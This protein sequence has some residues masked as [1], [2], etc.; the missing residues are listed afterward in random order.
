MSSLQKSD[1]FVAREVGE[2]M[3]LVPV[4]KARADLSAV[5]VLEGIGSHIWQLLDTCYLEEELVQRIVADYDVAPATAADDLRAF[6]DEL[7][8]VGALI[9]AENEE[10][11]PEFTNSV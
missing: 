10:S 7:R 5:L 8:E 4:A 6:L 11:S 2:E 1:D 9:D 3:I